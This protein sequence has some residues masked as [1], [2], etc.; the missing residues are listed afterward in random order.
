MTLTRSWPGPTALT[1]TTDARKA[2]S[3][4]IARDSS[5]NVRTGVFPRGTAA[6]V[7]SRADMNVNIAAFEAVASQFGG[8]ILLTNDG[9]AQLPSVL[10]APGSGS[11]YYVIY[12]KQNESTSPGTDANNN[13]LF[14]AALST[15][16]F[17]AAR[18]N[19]AQFPTG[20][21][22]LATVQVPTGATTTGTGGVV[23]TAS[24][25]FT[26]AEGGVVVLRDQT[27]ETAWA[28][29]DG[30]VGYRLD[31]DRPVW[32][33]DGLWRRQS[34]NGVIAE[35]HKNV[36]A[37]TAGG[38]GLAASG[39]S[40]VIA[41]ATYARAIRVTVQGG[42]FPSADGDGGVS[43]V[44]STGSWAGSTNTHRVKGSANLFSDVAYVFYMANLPAST[45]LTL[46]MTSVTSVTAG[47][48]LHFRIEEV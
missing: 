34:L 16:S 15:S 7:T 24:Y 30:G 38:A 40:Q 10:V 22:E 3:G 1:T 44:P 27:E 12:A 39:S 23:I 29:H 26:A 28:P 14:G 45:A 35:W 11:N 8:A 2:L 6:I 5:G 9:S 31:I 4:L 19:P 48:D 17:A 18:A 43:V 20:A 41:A 47:Y 32:R 33:V 25:Q 13:V 36:S 42:Y 46:T 37:G 21:V